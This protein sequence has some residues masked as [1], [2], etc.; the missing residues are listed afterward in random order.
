MHEYVDRFLHRLASTRGASPHTLRAYGA[1]LSELALFLEER[2]VT[3]PSAITPRSLRSYLARLDDRG[4]SKATVQRKLSSVRGLLN[5]LVREGHLEASPAAALRQRRGSRRLPSVLS[6]EEIEALLAAP[7]LTT[8]L[9][10]RD[11]ALLEV[12]YLSLIHI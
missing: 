7:D 6:L 4:L 2:G 11:R 12:M 9:G 1:D 8:P 5:N 10:R 3:E